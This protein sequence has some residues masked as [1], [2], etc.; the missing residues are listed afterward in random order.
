MP[1]I[2]LA[3]ILLLVVISTACAPKTVQVPER[4]PVSADALYAAAQ[5]YD[6]AQDLDKAADAYREFARRYPESPRAPQALMRVGA[7]SRARGQLDEALA[8]YEQV[9]S[10]Y[11]R[12][13]IGADALVEILYILYER[14]AYEQVIRRADDVLQYPVTTSNVYRAYSILGDAYRAA[15][16]PEA[17]VR[18][19]SLA[20]RFAP[21]E[22]RESQLE[23]LKTA[24]QELRIEQ[25]VSLLGHLDD[26][27]ARGYLLYRLGNRYLEAD[28]L[29]EAMTTLS[30]FVDLYPKHEY[31]PKAQAMV[32]VLRRQV[33]AMRLRIGCLLP[34]TGPSALFGLQ[35]LEGVEF[36]LDRFHA[37]GG[38][39]TV[40]LLVR[41]T[42]S[43]TGKAVSA[44][45]QLAEDGA[46]AI[47]GPI[48]TAAEAAAEAQ[49]LRIPLV[50]ITQK[51]DVAALGDYVF[52][53]FF[54]P[55]MQVKA[56][57]AY[58]V[59]R[60]G[61][62]RFAVLY[63][64]E[65]YGQTFM[66]LFWDEAIARGASVVA[67]ENYQTSVTD[68]AGPIRKL[69]GPYAEPAAETE[70]GGGGRKLRRIDFEALFIPDAAQRAAM[71]IPQLAY[72]DIPAVQLLGTNLWHSDDF[73][74]AARPYVQ[75]AIM[76][77]I[78]FAGSQ[79]P[80]VRNFV[81]EF[82]W[83]YERHPGF[84][85]AALYD[86]AMMLFEITTEPG[87]DSRY[88][89][90]ERLAGIA[91]FSGLTGP[92]AFDAN[93]NAQKSL[94]LLRIEGTGFMELPH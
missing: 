61:L 70:G 12:S 58:A 39:P 51:E 90:R 64:E 57:V 75:G 85:E 18:A 59:E 30:E 80:L 77:D 72:N 4:P 26:P 32:E 35:A 66:N 50:A 94:Y 41:D 17:A 69:A 37:A 22:S 87:A 36:A 14:G 19:Y 42:G 92:T 73:V 21:E 81:E 62:T 71:V 60:L 76:P 53:N 74:S 34:L 82:N 49:R 83:I 2:R 5:A 23:R 25:V 27:L 67:A 47:I 9:V 52:S 15:S 46:V 63:P 54:T 48:F 91:D 10:A 3:A 1:T 65:K 79:H 7:I 13:A 55:R 89:I 43:D 45:G 38:R 68:F 11:P 78:F 86:T 40:E 33:E 8:V 56:L 16:Q 6:S 31:A 44:V 28:R 93:G 88:S 24:V 29:R 20:V 84:I